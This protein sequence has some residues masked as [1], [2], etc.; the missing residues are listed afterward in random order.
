MCKKEQNIEAEK[1]HEK[2]EWNS[3]KLWLKI[4]L[5]I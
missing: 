2:N 1:V 3:W 4:L 5:F